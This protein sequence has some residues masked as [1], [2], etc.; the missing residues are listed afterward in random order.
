M[1]SLPGVL[2]LAAASGIELAESADFASNILTGFGKD[3]SE[4]GEIGDKLTYAFTNSNTSLTELHNGL[5]KVGGMSKK[6]GLTFEDMTAAM[7]TM[8]DAG[9]KAENAGVALSSSI[10]R[11]SKFSMDGLKTGRANM[12]T[13]TLA[14]LGIDIEE[15]LNT[16]GKKRATMKI[17]FIEFIQLLDA[18]GASTDDFGRIFGGD[19]TKAIL[20]LSGEYGKMQK[21]MHGLTY[22]Y[23]GLAKAHADM[24]NS[25]AEGG[26]KLLTSAA[27]DLAIALGS[28][29][30][31][32]TVDAVSRSL[33]YL[34]GDL[35]ETDKGIMRVISAV[36]LLT[37]VLGPVAAG[38]GGLVKLIRWAWPLVYAFFTKG[39]GAG[40]TLLGGKVLAIGGL[41][42]SVVWG[43]WWLAN[44]W[45]R[46]TKWMS[47]SW[48]TVKTSIQETVNTLAWLLQT[49]VRS[50][51]SPVEKFFH[52]LDGFGF[53][54]Y[55]KLN[56]FLELLKNSWAGKV[57]EYLG[58]KVEGNLKSSGGMPDE[59]KVTP[60]NKL[61]IANFETTD[62]LIESLRPDRP[63]PLLP[64]RYSGFETE[65]PKVKMFPD[66]LA[67]GFGDVFGED[68]A[69]EQ[70]VMPAP[71]VLETIYREKEN[72][73]KYDFNRI[74]NPGREKQEK[75]EIDINVNLSGSAP[76]DVR[77]TTRRRGR[78][79][80]TVDTGRVMMGAI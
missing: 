25:G 80:V 12:V 71:N 58:I 27:G 5:V 52:V 18:K 31:L 8:A 46:A 76:E 63:A 33:A 50:D 30:L 39:V 21:Y 34:V 54:G 9:Y 17:P 37:V 16:T 32:N 59:F 1:K 24:R 67:Q 4:M 42:L 72:S 77:V 60:A 28:T 29:G 26:F 2:N 44:N 56:Q 41:I 78:A 68:E 64:L 66:F 61:R 57:L 53:D 38:I 36:L 3:A 35:A 79:K 48:D 73:K 19:H 23:K 75:Q 47:E 7:M 45:E 70:K 6:A 20:G 65:L 22:E 10:L 43:I 69:Q 11:L 49:F 14:D 74:K 15:F 51:L 55:E 40:V 13:R 62:N